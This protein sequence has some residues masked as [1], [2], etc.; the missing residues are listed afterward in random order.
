MLITNGWIEEASAGWRLINVTILRMLN[1]G[2]DI[3]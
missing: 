3:L 1:F 2:R